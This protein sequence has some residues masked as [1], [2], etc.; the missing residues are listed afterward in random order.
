[1]SN[2]VHHKPITQRAK[3]Q[4]TVLPFNYFVDKR[5]SNKAFGMLCRLHAL[6]PTWEFSE[7][8]LVGLSKD[9]RTSVRSQLKELEDLG[10]LIRERKRDEKG[11]LGGCIYHVL[12]IPCS[13]V[14][15]AK[16]HD[17]EVQKEIE[18]KMKLFEGYYDWMA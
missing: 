16:Q 12:E 8:G 15:E 1:M 4:F 11:K 6:P 18:D 13:S 7:M 5:L 2:M 17:D 9:S 10:Y 14:E 3:S